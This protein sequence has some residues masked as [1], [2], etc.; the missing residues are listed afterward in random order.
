MTS[1]RHVS[2][3]CQLSGTKTLC[4]PA[5]PLS[6]RDAHFSRLVKNKSFTPRILSPAAQRPQRL[7]LLPFTPDWPWQLN[8][9]ITPWYPT[10]R[11]YR[12]AKPGDWLEVIARIAADLPSVVA[13]DAAA[14]PLRNLL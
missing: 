5:F 6:N 7:I 8:R 9:N 4:F 13:R 2:T 11:L 14:Q 1:T 10:A 3:R 12:Q